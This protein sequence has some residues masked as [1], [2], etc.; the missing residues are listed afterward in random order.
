MDKFFGLRNFL[1]ILKVDFFTENYQPNYQRADHY[2][3]QVQRAADGR[4]LRLETYYKKYQDLIKP[5]QI[6][7][8]Y[9]CE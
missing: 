6:L 8:T 2:I 5:P 9:R 3:F 1:K 4:S 7:Q